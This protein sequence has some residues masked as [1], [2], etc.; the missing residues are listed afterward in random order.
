MAFTAECP[1]CHLRVQNVPHDLAGSSTTCPRCRNLYTLSASSDPEMEVT[2]GPR[3]KARRPAVIAEPE[4]LSEPPP[5]PPPP[6]PPPA[7]SKTYG[8][9]TKLDSKAE[10]PKPEPRSDVPP[11][12]PTSSPAPITSAPA[13]KPRTINTLG[14]ASLLAASLALVSAAIPSAGGLCLLLAG[15]SMV[16]GMLGLASWL[17]NNNGAGYA[18]AGLLGSIVLLLVAFVRPTS[19]GVDLQSLEWWEWGAPGQTLVPLD[20]TG[21]Q[22]R[23][24]GDLEWVDARTGAIQQGDFQVSVQS[25]KIKAVK[26]PQPPDAAVEKSLVLELRVQNVGTRR[27]VGYKSWAEVYPG[28]SPLLK[29]NQGTA[30]RAV[31]TQA[32]P[33]EILGDGL[34]HPGKSH[35]D[36][37]T[38]EAPA[39][40]VEY[41]HLELPATAIGARGKFR[42]MI[43]RAMITGP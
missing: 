7:V 12:A 6:S 3:R 42:L 11:P 41:L 23:A 30:Y 25:A 33:V 34:L 16:F 28:N 13:A 21:G 32:D 26:P 10:T 19:L 37:L 36:A 38:F 29:D 5:A 2:V 1:F 4:R 43:P 18:C 8:D 27:S 20:N 24:V 40:T 14:V 35:R 39:T 9:W 22:P 31:G 17:L 15:V